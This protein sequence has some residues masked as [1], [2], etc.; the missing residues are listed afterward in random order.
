MPLPKLTKANYYDTETDWPY[1]SVSLFKSFMKC[2]AATMA[3]LNGNGLSDTNETPL[4]VGNWVHS[5]VESEAAHEEFK[6]EAG[7]KVLTKSGKLRAE[8][9]Q[10]D[11][12]IQRLRSDAFFNWA[13]QGEHE[14]IVTGE[15]FGTEWKGK[16]DCLDVENGRFFDL[17][18]TADPLKMI[19][20]NRHGGRVL[21]V[22]AYGYLLQ[23]SIYK[24]L[25][26]Q[27]YGK[28]FD[29]YIIA[30]SKSNHPSV[31]TIDLSR[32]EGRFQIED[33]YVKSH[34]PRILAIE[35][36]EI[37]PLMCNH[38]DWCA[39]HQLGENTVTIDDLEI[40]ANER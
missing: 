33:D 39:D 17:K 4:L 40:E 30:V 26:E 6:Q 20:S 31:R 11:L 34:L 21:W 38:C 28:H 36:G 18:T 16:I 32:E 8:F 9:K 19:W 1:M 5:A 37:P 24:H 12:M 29:A 22:T 15:L 27:T 14:S 10:A 2:E 25:L 7:E 13:W 23:M 35:S 3:T